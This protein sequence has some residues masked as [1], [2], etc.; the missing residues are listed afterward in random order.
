MTKHTRNTSKGCVLEV[1]L[2]YPKKIKG[3]HNDYPLA[4]DVIEA[5]QEVFPSY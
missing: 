2:K 4:P 5:R 1:N 3:L